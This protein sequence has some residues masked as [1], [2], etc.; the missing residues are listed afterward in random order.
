MT[1]AIQ[2]EN[3]SVQISG[4][5]ILRDICVSLEAGKLI[6]LIGPNGSGKTTLLNCMSGLIR[7]YSGAIHL[8]GDE[9]SARCG[10]AAPRK[11]V[12]DH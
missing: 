12:R 3:L 4:K 7:D 11:I 8:L 1:D 5:N 9:P 10:M 2:I 6:G